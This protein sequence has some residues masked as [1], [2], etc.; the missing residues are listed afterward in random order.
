MGLRGVEHRQKCQK[1]IFP[2]PQIRTIAHNFRTA[3]DFGLIFALSE[4]TLQNTSKKVS[5]NASNEV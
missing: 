3:Q 2:S 1:P 5:F 4:R